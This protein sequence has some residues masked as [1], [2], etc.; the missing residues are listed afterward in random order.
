MENLDPLLGVW[1]MSASLPTDG[2]PPH[3]EASFEWLDGGRFLIQRWRV[4]HP[5]APD[6]IAIIGA[7]ETEG[8]YR[9]HYFDSRGVARVYEMTLADGVWKLWRT[10]PG[11]SQRFTGTFNPAGDT[12]SGTWE[13]SRDGS[14]WEYDFDIT[15]TRVSR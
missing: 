11:F 2:D 5:A 3:A 4:D 9:Q 12:I 8:S 13:L 6:G 14:T 1:H 7:G 10:A 15:Y